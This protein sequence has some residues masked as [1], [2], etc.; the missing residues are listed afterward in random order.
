[1]MF[2]LVWPIF[3]LILHLIVFAYFVASMMLLATT[4]RAEFYRNDTGILNEVPCDPTVSPP[5]HT[6]RFQLVVQ[7]LPMVIRR[8]EKKI[9]YFKHSIGNPFKS[10]SVTCRMGSHSV[11]RHPIHVNAP[12]LDTTGFTVT[13]LAGDSLLTTS[14]DD[15]IGWRHLACVVSVS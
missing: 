7:I 8:L 3:P 1:M 11:T 2:T 10:A 13:H 15:M 6:R 14:G 4:G 12:W 9:V 5:E